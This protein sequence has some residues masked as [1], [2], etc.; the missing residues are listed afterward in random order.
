MANNYREG[1]SGHGVTTLGE[2]AINWAKAFVV[3]VPL[4]GLGAL[5]GAKLPAMLSGVP[6]ADGQTDVDAASPE[7]VWKRDV[8]NFTVESHSIHEQMEVGM[9]TIQAQLQARMNTLEAKLAKKDR[10]NYAVLNA[11]IIDT[12]ARL[13]TI[14][15]VVQP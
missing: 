13:D 5:G 11:R 9:I 3:I 15:E 6:D 4:L 8:T 1:E 12:E 10:S 2:R 14:D 7:A